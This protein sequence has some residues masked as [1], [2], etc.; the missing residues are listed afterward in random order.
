[1]K[2]TNSLIIIAM[3]TF[4]LAGCSTTSTTTTKTSS[5]NSTKNTEPVILDDVTLDIELADKNAG[6]N[7]K[8]VMSFLKNRIY[9]KHILTGVM[10]CAWDTKVK[11]DDKVF[12]DTGYHAALMGFDFMHLTKS[13]SRS[14]YNPNQVTKARDWWYHGGLVSF[15]W[16]WLDPS[17]T[18]ANGASYKPEEISFKIP[19]DSANKKLD[20]SN[21]DFEFIKKDLDTIAGYLAQLQKYDV[22]VIWRPMHEAAG[23]YGKYNGAGKAWFW[24]GAQGP[25][26]YIALYR[27]M[28][29]YFTN[30][31]KLHNLIWLWN[32]QE[33]DW[34]PGDEYVDLVGY[35]IY[36]DL[37]LSSANHSSRDSVYKKLMDWCGS[38]KMACISEG[39]FIPA[40]KPLISANQ[41]DINW[42]FYMIWNDDDSLADDTTSDNDNFWGGTKFNTIEDK[43][44]NSFHTD[45]QIKRNDPLL[46]ALFAKMDI[47]LLE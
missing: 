35:D 24:W 43:T 9:G 42:L 12:A 2:L 37:R 17:K 21:P 41:D 3:V 1:M 34:Y 15:C 8:Y 31:K 33:K 40:T 4:I 23:N 16:H 19:W 13:D 47:S 22:V 44:I 14:W 30:Q 46:D 36:E 45:Y 18:S 11:M 6:D 10:D 5:S 20:T 27:Y 39:G 7:T 29:D 26:P 25:E 28:F 38:N 32:G